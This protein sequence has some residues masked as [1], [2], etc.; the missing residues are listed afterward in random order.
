[1]AHEYWLASLRIR[2]ELSSDLRPGDANT[3]AAPIGATARLNSGRDHPDWPSGAG[4][5]NDEG[6]AFCRAECKQRSG[7]GRP[8]RSTDSIGEL[9][10]WQY[11]P[12]FSPMDQPRLFAL[13]LGP[14][15]HVD[16][17]AC[18]AASWGGL[19]FAVMI[20]CG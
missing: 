1:M 20:D 12:I 11:L 4:R 9:S 17:P 3:T 7:V 5:E 8:R 18:E 10:T 19:C 6:A 16:M 14:L 15:N 2:E 13:G